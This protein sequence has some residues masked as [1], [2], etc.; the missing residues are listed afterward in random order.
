MIC[1]NKIIFEKHFSRCFDGL[2]SVFLYKLIKVSKKAQ[3]QCFIELLTRKLIIPCFDDV[4][5]RDEGLVVKNS[6]LPCTGMP[7]VTLNN[8]RF[9]VF[10]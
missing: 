4:R 5:I 6:N 3:V 7:Y 8:D 10:I 2:P 9:L 1:A